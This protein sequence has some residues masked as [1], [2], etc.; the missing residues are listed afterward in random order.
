MVHACCDVSFF[1]HLKQQ[2]TNF[3]SKIDTFVNDL[4]FEKYNFK[5][6]LENIWS[7]FREP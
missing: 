7:F 1:H 6:F 3:M 4:A 2:L 5:I